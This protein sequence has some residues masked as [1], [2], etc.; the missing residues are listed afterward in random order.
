MRDKLIEL[1]YEAEGQVNNDIPSVEQIADYLLANGVNVQSE[2][3]WEKR[4]FIIFDSEKVGYKCLECN[5]TWDAPTNFC[6]N[7]GAH[8]KGGAE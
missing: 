2:G 1:L 8:M 3:E 6:P 4:T 7:C 5:T